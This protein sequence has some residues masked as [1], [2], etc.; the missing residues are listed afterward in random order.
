MI[1][2]IIDSNKNLKKAATS[3][4][5]VGENEFEEITVSCNR[6][7]LVNNIPDFSASLRVVIGENELSYPLAFS[8]TDSNT[9]TATVLIDTRM[10]R[11]VAEL[12]FYVKFNSGE[13]VGMT[14]AIKIECKPNIESNGDEPYIPPIPL[15]DHVLKSQTIAGIDQYDAITADELKEALDLDDKMGLA[16][17]NPTAAQIVLMP[18]GQFYGDT[19]NHKGVIKGG[20][21]F[22]D[23]IYI[24]NILASKQQKKIYLEHP[25]GRLDA[26]EN[27]T[28]D[29]GSNYEYN[30]IF[31]WNGNIYSYK[32]ISYVSGGQT[33]RYCDYYRISK[34]TYTVTN[35]PNLYVPPSSE[36]FSSYINSYGEGEYLYLFEESLYSLRRLV[37]VFLCTSAR[38]SSS[39]WAYTWKEIQLDVYSKSETNTL[40]NAKENISNKVIALSSESTDDQYPS[41]KCVYDSISAIT[42]LSFEVAQSKPTENIKTNVIYLIPAASSATGNVY[43]EWIYVNNAWELIGSTQIDLSNYY[44]KTQVDNLIPD[45][46]G[47]ENVSNKVTSYNSSVTDSQY[48]S[49]RC[50]Y[51]ATANK[52]SYNAVISEIENYAENKNNRLTGAITT[53]NKLL[54]TKY[55]SIKSITDY[56]DAKTKRY[57]AVYDSSEG[58]ITTNIKMVDF[59]ALEAASCFAVEGN[60]G[61]QLFID[62]VELPSSTTAIVKAHI[63]CDG[64]IKM[65]ETDETLA[66]ENLRFNEIQQ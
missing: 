36:S 21:S 28:H 49:A 47:K 20:Q 39:G 53:Q 62:S 14:N 35:Q 34:G 61:Y 37:R 57:S 13:K 44:T 23:T 18:D 60:I 30:D 6:R 64:D 56:V 27:P 31:Y 3:K 38:A 54:T 48:F 15:D 40:L 4:V 65:F 26:N 55:P 12:Q 45:V 51:N 11:A 16:P 5:F 52:P 43:E 29:D 9:M 17:L 7:V 46:S 58:T 1:K 24:D 41:A 8:D 66:T 50:I 59:N 33:I 19:V 22:Y 32:Y 63:Y 10:T 42:T 2:L 25:R